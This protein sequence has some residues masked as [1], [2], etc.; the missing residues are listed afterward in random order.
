M[1]RRR[2][3]PCRSI[4]RIR[5]VGTAPFDGIAGY[6]RHLPGLLGANRAILRRA[7]GDGRPAVAQGPGLERDAGR[8]DRPLRTARRA[9]S[10]SPAARPRWP[11]PGSAGSRGSA[12]R[13]SGS[14]TTRSADWPPSAGIASRSAIGWSTATASW[15]AWSKPGELRDPAGRPW[16]PGRDGGSV[17]LAWAG[18]LVA[19]K[20]LEAMH[21]RGGRRPDARARAPRRR[22]GPRSPGRARRR[23]AAPGTASG[24]PATSPSGRP[25]ST[26]WPRRMP[27]SSRR[28]PRASP[29]S[30]LDAFAVGLP[31]LA[32]PVGAVGELVEAD[33]VEPIHRPDRPMPCSRPGGDCR[34]WTGPRSRTRRRRA[35]A[36]A[37][38]HTGRPEAARLV[39][40]WRTWWPDLPWER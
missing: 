8:G 23:R 5:V 11:A 39:E 7:I 34:R 29:R 1:P 10:G 14:A 38:R 22:A 6:L 28:R 20:G 13:P 3:R 4:P 33:L 32:T 24:G 21:R 2:R 26:A 12:P 40:R 25:T 17:R 36:F 15:P 35:H 30:L 37:A 27:S 16:T 19:G 18:R 31:V 9:S